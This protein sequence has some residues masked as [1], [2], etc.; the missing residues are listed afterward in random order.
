MINLSRKII[1]SIE[2]SVEILDCF[3][4][5]KELGITEIAEATNYSKST[6][7]DVVSTLTILGLLKRNEDTKRY[8]LGIKLFEYGYL[9]SQRNTLRGNVKDIGRE[10][11]DKYKS[12]CHLATFD[13]NEIIYLDKFEYQ[14]SIVTSYTQIGKRVP[15]TV[16]GLGKAMLAFLPEEYGK[17]FIYS[18]PLPS[19]TEYSI[20]DIPT[21]K[22][23]LEEIRV[24]GYAIDN[25]ESVLGLRCIA[26]P[27]FD[28]NNKIVAA[29]SLSLLAPYFPDSLIPQISQDITEAAN[30]LSR[31][32]Y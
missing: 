21:L 23:D 9:F 18:Q 11:S 7:H 5:H 10:L 20:T 14:G 6:I 19:R 4:D 30:N 8:S 15:M 31:L 22:A 13:K 28:N 25:Q 32:S 3:F 17:E 24:N 1:K 27:I 2:K 12:T 26:C 29:I 16:T